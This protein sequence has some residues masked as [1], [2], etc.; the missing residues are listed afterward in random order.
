MESKDSSFAPR[1]QALPP[2]FLAS[3]GAGIGTRVYLIARLADADEADRIAEPL[4]ATYPALIFVA[5]W[6]AWR[7]DLDWRGGWPLE[8]GRCAAGAIVTFPPDHLIGAGAF[9][10]TADFAVADKPL[11]WLAGGRSHGRFR[12]IDRFRIEPPREAATMRSV[13]RLA[14]DPSA[15]P[16]RPALDGRLR[17]ALAVVERISSAM[18]AAQRNPAEGAA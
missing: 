4:T 1:S 11:I 5:G 8:C 14:A 12:A 9:R 17:R 16:L 3:A 2:A 6:R 7:D 18:A 15:E 10:E 13:A